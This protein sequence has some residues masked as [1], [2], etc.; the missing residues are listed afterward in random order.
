MKEPIENDIKACFDRVDFTRTS[1]KELI[2]DL[3]AMRKP[4]DEIIKE[5]VYYAFTAGWKYRE[6][7]ENKI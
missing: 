6:E 4:E 2:M 3:R 7:M 5:C 1:L